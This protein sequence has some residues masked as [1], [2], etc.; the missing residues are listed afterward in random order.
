MNTQKGNNKKKKNV[1][2]ADVENSWNISNYG[3]R[4]KSEKSLSKKDKPSK[5]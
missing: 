4:L 1:T 5:K 2:D 3:S